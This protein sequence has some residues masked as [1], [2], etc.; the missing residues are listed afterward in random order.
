M[1]K[2]RF[3]RRTRDR[4]AVSRVERPKSGR[5]TKTVIVAF[6]LC[7]GLCAPATGP[8]LLSA[9]RPG[10]FVTLTARVTGVARSQS[11]VKAGQEIKIVYRG[12]R[13]GEPQLMGGHRERIV[14]AGSRVPAFLRKHGEYYS[15]AAAFCFRARFTDYPS[16][17]GAGNEK[18]ANPSST[19]AVQA[20]QA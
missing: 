1:A 6:P 9:L 14:P 2:G 20:G 8:K 19:M 12:L 7:S 5:S 13:D 11:N 15:S 3:A 4:S 18:P 10:V 17:P 16:T